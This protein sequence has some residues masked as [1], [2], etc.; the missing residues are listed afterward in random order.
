MAI[1]LL[2]TTFLPYLKKNTSTVKLFSRKLF[3]EDQDNILPLKGITPLSQS[4]Q[5]DVRL[6]KLE[7]SKFESDFGIRK[8]FQDL[9][10]FLRHNNDSLSDIDKF[11]YFFSSLEDAPLAL[12]EKTLLTCANYQV[13]YQSLVKRYVNERLIA[14]SHWH[15]IE[16]TKNFNSAYDP[17]ALRSSL[18][19]FNENILIQP[20]NATLIKEEYYSTLVEFLNEYCGT[21][22]TVGDLR[23]PNRKSKSP[24]HQN[25]HKLMTTTLTKLRA[26]SAL[27][28]QSNN[29]SCQLCHADH[30][31]YNSPS[32]IAKTPNEGCS[33]KKN[34][35][36]C[37]N[38][39]ST[40]HYASKCTF[41]SHCRKGSRKHHALLHFKYPESINAFFTNSTQ[42]QSM[43]LPITT[44]ST[45]SCQFR[46]Y[47]H[48][49][50]TVLL[51]SALV[52]VR[53]SAGYFQT[54][55]AVNSRSRIQFSW[56]HVLFLTIL[57]RSLKDPELCTQYKD[58]MRDL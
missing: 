37:T 58:N 24:P 50:N 28:T 41:R 23:T 5:P 43:P 40:E 16:C 38:C 22:N 36:W 34:D 7:L 39:L 52:E 18:D 9:F 31:I 29:L 56:V 21:S 25:E 55:R 49:K 10:V 32:F 4:S 53:D 35:E 57:R 54:I 30:M 26:S 17:L 12:I 3:E 42:S 14:T 8:T 48:D 33:L 51:S 11:N 15:V 45:L 46:S 13:A 1:A 6:P 20:T 2:R 44:S 27:L 19:S 47:T